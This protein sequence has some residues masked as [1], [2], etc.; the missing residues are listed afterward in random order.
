M[1]DDIN[2]DEAFSPDEEAENS[3]T[4]FL[5]SLFRVDRYIAAAGF[6]IAVVHLI[7]LRSVNLGLV[8]MFLVIPLAMLCL[9]SCPTA[10]FL[11]KKVAQS[12]LG[13]MAIGVAL[14]P[15]R[16]ILPNMRAFNNIPPIP[17]RILTWYVGIYL[18]YLMNVIPLAAFGSALRKNLIGE[19]AAFTTFTCILGLFAW[20]VM[21]L[22]SLWV[23]ALAM[24]FI[25]M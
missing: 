17:N 13:L 3:V 6:F 11:Q 4:A 21:G 5:K 7:L 18:F 9:A 23:I 19:K 16:E 22:S 14:A 12:F 8:L 2:D 25:K 15:L 1:G 20:C 24:G 10:T